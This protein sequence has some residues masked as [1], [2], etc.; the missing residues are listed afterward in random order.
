MTSQERAEQIADNVWFRLTAR[1]AMIVTPMLGVCV[2]TLFF[3]WLSVQFTNAATATAE[4]SA[5]VSALEA[6]SA[7]LVTKAQDH[8]ARLT[9]GRQQREEFQATARQQ[10]GDVNASLRDVASKL[11]DLNVAVASVKTMLN[12]RVPRKAEASP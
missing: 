9:F 12:E 2:T 8:E 5:R 6:V 11:Q 7:T 3:W 1:A 10:F 4:L